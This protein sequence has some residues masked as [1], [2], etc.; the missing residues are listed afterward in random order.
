VNIDAM[1]L[2]A[3]ADEWRLLLPG[4]RI[5]TIIQP[6][7]YALACQ[8]YI[9]GSEGRSGQN[10]WLYL[11]AHPQMARAHLTA[12]KPSKIA[13]E[14]PP[15]VM[16]LR[17]Y[18]EGARIEAVVQPR[19]ERILEIVAGYRKSQD[20]DER[21]RFRLIIEI[22]GRHSNII[23]C[24]EEG[25]ILGCLKRIGAEVNRYRIV[26]TGMP[27][28]PPPPQGHTVAGQLLPRLNPA[29]VSAAQLATC[30]VEDT[31]EAVHQITEKKRKR[32]PEKAVLWQLLTR[33]LS[34]CSPLLAREVVYRTTGETE[35]PVEL[36]EGDLWEKLA[37][38]MRE[39]AALYDNHN[40]HP[41]LIERAEGDGGSSLLSPVVCAPY[42]LEQYI[43]TM[44]M[45]VRKSPSINILLDD[46][47]ARTEWYDALEGI[48]A[49]MR[50]ILQTQLERCK[51]KAQ[52]LQQ[53]LATA[54]EAARYRLQAELL[55]AHQQKVQQGQTSA[56][57]Q[58][59]FEDDGSADLPMVTIELDPRFNAVENARQLFNKYHK[60]RRALALVPGQSEQNA[61]ELATL[62]Q[63]LADLMLAETP[64]EVALV[65]AELQEAGYMRNKQQEKRVA[66]KVKGGKQKG[67][68]G[69]PGG[70]VP[71]HI[72]TK[73][74]FT[75]L[76]GKN[77]RQNEEVTFR[78]AAA[79]DIWLHARG[80]PGA[81][82]IIKAAGREVPRSQ[83]EEAACLAAYY[84]QAR[85]STNVPVDY[86]LQ[87]HVRHMKGAGPGMVIYER[88]HTLYSDPHAAEQ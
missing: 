30:S 59:F 34:G 87:R 86:T 4:A 18:L 75:V 33:H 43:Q 31:A 49:P 6:T 64:A 54:K 51:R 79:N 80:V 83:I 45:H 39:L 15:F 11:S 66:K 44:G 1:T 81:H 37:W 19:W 20:S 29:S 61:V 9:S 56:T 5:D 77:S 22:M 65:K 69:Q 35:T 26:A 53:E 73:D 47:F 71:L 27:Y 46:F 67:K 40:W 62:E 36:A 84:S 58:N 24:N 7:E 48:R 17:K 16:L 68:S 10:R 38:H 52:L 72:R 23:L 21:V 25:M 78:Q 76:I 28:V 63:L 2:A 57:V 3:V 85:G 12:R 88:E 42:V 74:G 60:L 50:K 32:T 8:C 13:S 70:G 41:Q 82:V 55:L 14:P